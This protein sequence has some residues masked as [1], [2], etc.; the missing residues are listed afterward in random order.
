M[1]KF[2]LIG[3]PIARSLSP[4]LFRASYDGRYPYELIQGE[5]FEDSYRRFLEEYDGVNVTAPFKELAYAKADIVSDECRLAKAANLMVKTPEGIKAY[6]SDLLGVRLW[7]EERFLDFARN[8]NGKTRN[9]NGDAQSEKRDDRSEKQVTDNVPRALIAGCGGAGRAAAAAA[10]SLGLK[11]V[12]MNRNPERARKLA[13]ELRDMG[14]VAE[15]QP[16]EEFSTWFRKSD[17][18]IYNIPTAIPQLI[19]LTDSCLTP[20]GTKYVLEANYKDPSFDEDMLKKLPS[21][22]YTGGRTWLLYQA[23]T[24]YEIFTGERPDLQKMSDVL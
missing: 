4:A 14:Y 24:G 18:I 12:L 21:V 23:L 22:R 10:A 5:D 6:N 15:A 20:G 3:H 16:M 2:G 9:D 8:D 17:I 13:E 19:T 11:A 7:L 1:K